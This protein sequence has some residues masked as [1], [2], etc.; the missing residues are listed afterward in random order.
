MNRKLPY[1]V[2]P[3]TRTGGYFYAVV[4]PVQI[5]APEIN[6]PRTKRFEAIIDSGASSCQFNAS[7]GAAIGLDIEKGD[8][9]ETLGIS[10]SNEI[11]MHQISLYLPGGVVK[12][13]AGFSKDLP[14]LGLLGMSG[15]FEHF[16]VIFDSATLQ[17]ELERIFHA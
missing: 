3:D 2:Y 7:I 8:K 11:Y 14:V 9:V 4:M 13:E 10:G 16:K 15:F 12:T 6:S 5:A 1:K 17:C